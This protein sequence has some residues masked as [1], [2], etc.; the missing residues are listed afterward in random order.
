LSR[1]PDFL[2]CRMPLCLQYL[3]FPQVLS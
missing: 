2:I 1:V 3:L